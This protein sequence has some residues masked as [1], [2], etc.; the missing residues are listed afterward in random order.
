MFK[1]LMDRVKGKVVQETQRQTAE[2]SLSELNEILA[3]LS[4]RPKVTVD[5]ATGTVEIAL[6]EQMPDEALALPAP[7]V[8]EEK[9]EEKQ[10]A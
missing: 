9:A 2:R 8:Q 1:F 5:M 10:A 4:D 3:G 6:P 7:E